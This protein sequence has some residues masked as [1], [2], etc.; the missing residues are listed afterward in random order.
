[1][2]PWRK[3]GDL[4]YLHPS[5]PARPGDHV[6]VEMKSKREGEPGRAYLKLLVAK[7]PTKLRLA[8]Y[9]PPDDRIEID[10]AKVKAIYR[11][12]DWPEL[13]GI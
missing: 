4:V 11:V 13:L 6:V 5:R 2:T 7:G 10:L 9:N 1:M 3:P 8:Q 12:I